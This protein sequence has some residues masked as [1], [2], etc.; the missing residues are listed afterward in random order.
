[1]GEGCEV[2]CEECGDVTSTTFRIKGKDVCD[3]CRKKMKRRS[4]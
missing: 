3:E 4:R 2:I 1:M